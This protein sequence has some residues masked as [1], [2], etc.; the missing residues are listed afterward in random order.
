MHFCYQG[1]G[2]TKPGVEF[3]IYQ[4]PEAADIIFRETPNAITVMPYDPIVINKIS[5]VRKLSLIHI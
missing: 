5:K 3:N 4:D 1:Y 2:N